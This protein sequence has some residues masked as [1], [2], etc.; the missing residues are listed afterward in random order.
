MEIA[1]IAAVASNGA[2]LAIDAAT[3][4]L[5]GGLG[6]L[7]TGAHGDPFEIEKGPDVQGVA[8]VDDKADDARF[9][10][11]VAHDGEAFNGLEFSCSVLEERLFVSIDGFEA[12]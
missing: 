11:G 12:D 6:T 4:G 7:V 3:G 1:L 8:T 9:F 5:R 10:R 2:G